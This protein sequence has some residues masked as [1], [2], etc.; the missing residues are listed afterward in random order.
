MFVRFRNVGKALDREK[1][2]ALLCVPGLGLR[3]HIEF[4]L[5]M[6]T[7]NNSRIFTYHNLST[8]SPPC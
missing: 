8:L 4:S 6:P 1:A 5:S 2:F 7:G 3:V